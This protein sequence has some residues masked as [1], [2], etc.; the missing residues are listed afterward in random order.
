MSDGNTIQY[1]ADGCYQI[2]TKEDYQSWYLQ[3]Q[4]DS[5][6]AFSADVDILEAAGSDNSSIF[7]K[8]SGT[9]QWVRPTE[10][11]VQEMYF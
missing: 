1:S 3:P 5:T 11:Y 8:G 7:G 6:V 2:E 10:G 9:S 4:C